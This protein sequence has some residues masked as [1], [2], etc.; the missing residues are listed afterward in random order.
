MLWEDKIDTI[1]PI[2]PL[3]TTKNMNKTQQKQNKN[4]ETLKGGEKK[5]DWPGSLR[6]RMISLFSFASYIPRPGTE[7]VHK[8]EMPV[9]A[10]RQRKCPNKSM[11]F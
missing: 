3:S 1:L 6:S 8:L 9:N 11:F 4:C 10:N 2:T 7:G 5:E